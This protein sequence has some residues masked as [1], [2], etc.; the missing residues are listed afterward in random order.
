[1]DIYVLVDHFHGHKTLEHFHSEAG[2][3]AAAKNQD[4]EEG[5]Y[6]TVWKIT[7][8]G[9]TGAWVADIFRSCGSGWGISVLCAGSGDVED[10]SRVAPV[11]G[12]HQA[13]HIGAGAPHPC[14]PGMPEGV[15]VRPGEPVGRRAPAFR[16]PRWIVSQVNACG[17]D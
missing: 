16:T 9:N 8:E 15:K 11:P 14:G 7:T 17:D 1:M 4:I 12:G 13:L 10:G 3:I 5:C 2:S 6:L